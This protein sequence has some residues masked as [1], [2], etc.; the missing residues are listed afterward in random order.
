MLAVRS[1]KLFLDGA[2]GSRG[3]EMSDAY[4]DAPHEHGLELMKDTDLERIVRLARQKGFQVNTHAIGDRA[5]RR[6]LDA[7]EKAGVTPNDRFRIEHASIVTNDDLPRFVHMGVIASI[8][9]MFV[10]EYSRW[11]EDRVGSSRVHWVLRTRDF[12]NAGVALAAGSDYPASDSGIP[13]D[14]LNCLVTR[15]STSGRPETGWYS[16]QR[17]DVDQALRMMTEGPAFAAFQEK[18]L[19]TLTVGRYADF[20]VVSGNPYQAASNALRTL[21]I[22]M[23]VVA[24]RVTFDAGFNQPMARR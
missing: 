17:V 24:G 10:G 19:G 23:T 15:Q 8:Q 3:A 6:A 5:V 12:L 9:P 7:F 11:A 16:E 22:R 2:L 21:T 14:T 1:F 20:T 13:L 4:S 18:N